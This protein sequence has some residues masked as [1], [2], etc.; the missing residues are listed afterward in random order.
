[1]A[2]IT[3]KEIAQNTRV[4]HIGSNVYFYSFQT[5]EL[6]FTTSSDQRLLV[7]NKENGSAKQYGDAYN[8]KEFINNVYEYLN[9]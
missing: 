4:K 7:E 3:K 9:D 1:M 8:K 2:K 5:N 6:L